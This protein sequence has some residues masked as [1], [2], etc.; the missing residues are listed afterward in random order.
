MFCCDPTS[1]LKVD[2]DTD[3]VGVAKLRDGCERC[4]RSEL[5][6][7]RLGVI[8]HQQSSVSGR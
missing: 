8:G 5:S 6:K 7:S 2:I 4:T 3:R 1:L